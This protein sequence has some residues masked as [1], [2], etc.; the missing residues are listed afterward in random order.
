MKKMLF[1]ASFCFI[2][3]AVSAAPTIYGPTGLIT[4]PT[5]ESLKYKQV[6]IAYDYLIASEASKDQWYYKLNI[7]TFKNWEMG[8]VGGKTPT[9]GMFLNVKYY[10]LESGAR[11]PLSVAIG[12]DNISSRDDTG[13]YM[14]ASKR[15]P[16]G[17]AAHFGFKAIFAQRQIDPTVMGGLEFMVN[18]NFSIMTDISGQEDQYMLNFGGHYLLTPELSFRAALVD[19]FSTGPSGL[20]YSLG[21][22]FTTYL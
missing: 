4:V 14:V 20:A 15:F 3:T 2:A 7:G 1:I 18:N 22:A 17:L 21:L 8:V 10:L 5:A 19:I 6:N 13:V 11:Y 16:E 12:A 9:E